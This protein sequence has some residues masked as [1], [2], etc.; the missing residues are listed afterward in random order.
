MTGR[1]R[2]LHPHRLGFR[3]SS[4]RMPLLVLLTLSAIFVVVRLGLTMGT[5]LH[6][7]RLAT[8]RVGFG[9]PGDGGWANHY[10]DLIR[11]RKNHGIL[12]DGRL[13]GR[14]LF[15]ATVRAGDLITSVDGVSLAIFPEAFFTAYRRAQAGRPL[16]L[17][18]R[19]ADGVD[20]TIRVVAVPLQEAGYVFQDG[21][22]PLRLEALRR[23]VAFHRL[24]VAMEVIFLS[25]AVILMIRSRHDTALDAAAVLMSQALWISVPDPASLVRWPAAML[26]LC[27]VASGCGAA[28][29]VPASVRLTGLYPTRPTDTAPVE[30]IYRLAVIFAWAFVAMVLVHDGIAPWMHAYNHAIATVGWAYGVLQD[31]PSYLLCC[32]VLGRVAAQRKWYERWPHEHKAIAFAY[33][34]GIAF[35]G[36][37]TT[38]AS[39]FYRGKMANLAVDQWVRDLDW[40]LPM[41]LL[42]AIAILIVVD[43]LRHDRSVA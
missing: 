5:L 4:R 19:R 22:V 27:S 30:H 31:A 36:L 29:V 24:L 37:Y 41:I 42:I 7:H 25:C 6:P 15:D 32:I 20:T 26:V 18:I 2:T 39:E 34:L 28:W 16:V 33:L 11:I 12:Q 3:T 10:F 14:P 9:W 17:G 13:I 35:E 23:T 40:Q 43:Q 38:T 8:V 21:K 1:T